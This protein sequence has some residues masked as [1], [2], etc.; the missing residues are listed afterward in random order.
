MQVTGATFCQLKETRYIQVDKTSIPVQSSHKKGA[1]HKGY[2]WV[3]HLPQEGIVVFDYQKSR[4][5]DAPES[6][7]KGFSGCLQTD[8]YAA[9]DELGKDKTVTHLGCMAHAR[10]KFEQALDNDNK[11][12]S[13]M[14]TQIQKLYAL[15]RKA[16]EQQMTVEQRFK[17]GTG[18]SNFGR[19]QT[20]A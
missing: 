18:Q 5:K 6:T 16:D 3:Y 12:S 4:G 13:H 8:G 10:R 11:R 14:L 20:M 19:N 2:H 17:R 1:T 7:L 9:Y 15:E